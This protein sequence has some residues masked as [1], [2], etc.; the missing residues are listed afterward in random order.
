MKTTGWLFTDAKNLA[1]CPKCKA[2]A[3][4]DCR[5]P[6]GRRT[7][8]PHVERLTAYGGQPRRI[9]LHREVR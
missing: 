7:W 8:P 6:S 3:G 9:D 1:D 4:S 2:V 5:M